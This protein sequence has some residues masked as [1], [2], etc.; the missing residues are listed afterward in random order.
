VILGTPNGVVGGATED[1]GHTE[2]RGYRRVGG[3]PNLKVDPPPQ[4]AAAAWAPF[5]L[6]HTA[7]SGKLTV[8]ETLMATYFVGYD[9]GMPGRD[10]EGLINYLKTFGT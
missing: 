2:E 10:Y 4:Q 5:M 1:V 8:T 3:G 7:V 6:D 9:L